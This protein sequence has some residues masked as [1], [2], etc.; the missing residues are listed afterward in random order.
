MCF[1]ADILLDI[2]R[3]RVSGSVKVSRPSLWRGMIPRVV[4]ALGMDP[5]KLVLHLGILK[6]YG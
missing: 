6:P 3:A 1:Q 5:G 4:L 2:L